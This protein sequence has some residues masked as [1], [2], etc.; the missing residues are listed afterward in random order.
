MVFLA[1]K[2]GQLVV[3]SQQERLLKIYEG[4]LADRDRQILDW[5]EV[6]RQH[7]ERADRAMEIATANTQALEAINRQLQQI[8]LT[9]GRRAS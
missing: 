3:G 6:S 2:T 1:L 9:E 7:D 8:I 4:I 5:R